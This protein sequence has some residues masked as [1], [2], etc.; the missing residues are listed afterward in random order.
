[1]AGNVG[2]VYGPGTKGVCGGTE[3]KPRQGMQ[4]STGEAIRS[5]DLT[6]ATANPIPASLSRL[7][8]TPVPSLTSPSLPGFL[9]NEVSEFCP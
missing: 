5:R 9:E 4:K 1:M 7:Q 6:S 3:G 8:P 2:E